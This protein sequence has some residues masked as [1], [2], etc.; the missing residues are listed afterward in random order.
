MLNKLPLQ[1]KN[2]PILKLIH[3]DV[4]NGL[5]DDTTEFLRPFK[6]RKHEISVEHNCLLWETRVII[7]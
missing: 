5:P 4:M 7:P 2:G 1:Q 6:V 3:E